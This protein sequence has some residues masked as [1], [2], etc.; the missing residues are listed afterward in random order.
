MRLK[1]SYNNSM[2]NEMRTVHNARSSQNQVGSRVVTT[3]TIVTG[4]SIAERALGFL[5]RIVLS[6]LIGAEG[7]G[8]YQVAL[9]IFSVFI[10]LGTG[11]IPITVSRLI[12][13]S[14]AENNAKGV[15]GAFTA[16][17]TLSLALTLPVCILLG[18]FGENFTF[19]FSDER[20]LPVFQILLGGLVFSAL[21]AVVRGSF[22]GHKE[23]LTPSVL[24]IAE[25]SVMVIAGVLLL[26]SVP[27]PLSGAKKAAW[28]VVISYL[29]SFTASTVCFL[30]RGGRI[31]SPKNELK[32]LVNA[33]LPITSVRV[34]GT[35][36]NSAVAVLFPAMLVRAGTTNTEAL[37]LFGVVSG[38]AIPILMIP[39]TVIGSLSLVLVPELAE[40]YYRKNNERLY[41]NIER[42]LL[43]SVLV[44]CF[45]LPFFYALGEDLGRIAYSNAL[46][47]EMI[48]KSSPILLPMSLSMITTGILNSLGFEKQ[49]FI[50]YFVGAAAM[51]LC[52]FILPP[53]C[54]VYAYIIGMA[55]NF[56]LNSICNFSLLFQKCRGFYRTHGKSV[57]SVFARCVIALLPLSLLGKL[58]SSLFKRF[59]GELWAVFA[60]GFALLILTALL[61]FVLNIFSPKILK[62]LFHKRQADEEK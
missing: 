38:M 29:F 14:K 30:L 47:G 31:S 23:F 45:L 48:M 15:S 24:E 49:T 59:L 39:S 11:G 57:V 56:T 32:P 35:L 7:L 36:V 44:S 12:T 4:L 53:V 51:L 46:A 28:A 19:L 6:R 37:S 16:G 42:G 40:D 5:Y 34:S 10:T 17:A 33:T 22:W 52:I 9:S 60:S 13:K 62:A 1:G 20:C 27:D 54:G 2:K 8:L 25:E 43:I 26:Q 21:Y 61:W 41:K 55:A 50:Y 58:L 3:A 18:V